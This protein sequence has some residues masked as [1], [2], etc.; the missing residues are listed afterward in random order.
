MA[1]L[2][3][4]QKRALQ[5]AYEQAGYSPASVELFEAH[6][7]GTVAGDAAEIQS[8]SELLVEHGAGPRQCAVGSV[9]TMIGHTKGSAGV[10]GLIKAA[11]ALHHRVFP[12]HLGVEQPNAALAEPDCP[13]ALHQQMRPWLAQADSPRRAGVSG[14]G[15]GGTNYPRH[16]GRVLRRVPICGARELAGG[17]LRLARPRRDGARRRCGHRSL[18]A[19][20]GC[21]PS[22]AGLARTLAAALSDGRAT[23][24]IMAGSHSTLRGLLAQAVARLREPD[25]AKP[26]PPGV[27]FS[28][29]PLA[30]DGK[31]AMLFAGQ[32]SQYPGHAARS[33]IHLRRGARRAG[34][35][36]RCPV[37][38][39]D[40]PAPPRAAP[41]PAH[42]PVRPLRR[43]RGRRRTP[44]TRRDRRGA[45]RARRGRSRT[46]GADVAARPDAGHGR[47]PQLRR[48]CRPACGG[49]TEPPRSAAR[50][51]GARPLHRRCDARRRSRHDGGGDRRRR[52]GA[53]RDPRHGRGRRQRQRAEP[54]GYLRRAH[55]GRRR[56]RASLRGGPPGVPD[57]GGGRLPLAAH[58]AGP[59]TSR[60]V[61]QRTGLGGASHPRLRQ[62]HR[63]PA[64]RA[65]RANPRA[66]RPASDRAGRLPGDGRG[67]VRG[68]RAH[69]PGNRPEGSARR[70]DAAHPRQSP[71]L[72]RLAR[73]IG[74]RRGRTAARAGGSHRS[75][76]R[77]R[78]LAAVRRP[79]HRAR[80]PHRAR[81]ARHARPTGPQCLVGQRRACAARRY[82]GLLAG[83]HADAHIDA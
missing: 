80:R 12:P 61:L 70:T 5:R 22:L 50:L 38:N 71:A 46:A 62:H 66:S 40:L 33:R 74:R 63:R 60:A 34:G 64:R 31:L 28:D 7:T 48:V 29:S 79:V 58:A 2:P 78:S 26:F 35:S 4:G 73:R 30:A 76:R 59:G 36:R 37:G 32:G 83:C 14:F 69:L 68:G 41:E 42:L 16:A 47:R 19:R 56:D 21:G 81:R 6:G 9:K 55:R 39:P 18:R 11:L 24:A 20:L 67:D 23:L 8:L 49:R 3:S 75:G 25:S 10:A 65:A 27:Y 51:R 57:P 54:D 53:Q 17:A 43:R 1:P 15:F 45:A 13:I 82:A 77:G 72:R 52:G 44:R